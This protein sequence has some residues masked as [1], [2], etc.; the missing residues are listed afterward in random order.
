LS[1]LGWAGIVRAAFHA[2]IGVEAGLATRPMPKSWRAARS[3]PWPLLERAIRG[4][5]TLTYPRSGKRRL[6][7]LMPGV[8][9]AR[10][11]DR[12]A[13]QLRAICRNLRPKH[14]V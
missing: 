9:C 6:D 8:T 14:F 7:R 13:P 3:A 5:V 10:R 12:L 1:E 2:G 11:L 4:G